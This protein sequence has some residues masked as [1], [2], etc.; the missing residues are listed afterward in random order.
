MWRIMFYILNPRI[1]QDLLSKI[2]FTFFWLQFLFPWIL[3]QIESFEYIQT[4]RNKGKGFKQPHGPILAEAHMHNTM[5]RPCLTHSTVAHGQETDPRPLSL[6]LVQHTTRA[7][8]PERSSHS[9]AQH[10]V[11]DDGTTGAEVKRIGACGHPRLGGYPPDKT[12]MSLPTSFRWAPASSHRKCG[13]PVAASMVAWRH[14][15]AE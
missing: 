15:G 3:N 6:A 14:G 12:A 8:A 11:T 1:G 9:G 13:W 7:P 10:G 2:W 5:A 4:I